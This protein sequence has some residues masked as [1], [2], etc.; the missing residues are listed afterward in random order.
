MNFD[1]IS[2]ATKNQK[3]IEEAEKR[4]GEQY[5]KTVHKPK[6]PNYPELFS[7]FNQKTQTLI[8]NEERARK[9]REEKPEMIVDYYDKKKKGAGADKKKV[10]LPLLMCYHKLQTNIGDPQNYKEEHLCIFAFYST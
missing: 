5:Y 7:R 9:A 2:M 4:N 1:F 3:E 10:N 6:Q 8:S